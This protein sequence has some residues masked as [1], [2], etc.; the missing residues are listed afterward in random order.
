MHAHDKEGSTWAI[1]KC[2]VRIKHP[3]Q[4]R[5]LQWQRTKKKIKE[6]QS[7]G[8]TWRSR[9]AP[10][11]APSRFLF[12]PRTP[13]VFALAEKP[14][15][16][17]TPTYTFRLLQYFFADCAVTSRKS[18]K[19]PTYEKAKLSFS[20]NFVFGAGGVE[21]SQRPVVFIPPGCS[22]SKAQNP[23]WGP[24]GSH[25]GMVLHESCYS[26]GLNL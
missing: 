24:N 20:Q 17:P 4:E 14:T 12:R 6:I 5:E 10:V 22:V 2:G 21:I 26:R 9:T 11:Q 1:N 23:A 7:V 25:A 3:A 18:E 16:F 8:G 13:L 15:L 19:T